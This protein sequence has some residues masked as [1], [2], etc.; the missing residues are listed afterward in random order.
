MAHGHFRLQTTTTPTYDS[1]MPLPD[2]TQLA[3]PSGPQAVN[4]KHLAYAQALL[5]RE[6]LTK[7]RRH[8]LKLKTPD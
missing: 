8:H 7:R 6:L 2:L 1:A 5:A 3:H 4:L